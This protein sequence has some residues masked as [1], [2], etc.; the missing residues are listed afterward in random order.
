MIN[1]SPEHIARLLE[2]YHRGHK[3]LYVIVSNDGSTLVKDPGMDRPWATNNKSIADFHCKEIQK[4]TRKKCAVYL[5]E[6]ALPLIL[7]HP[8]NQPKFLHKS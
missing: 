1:T 6:E 7:R 8:K 5:L 2:S 3:R 4:A